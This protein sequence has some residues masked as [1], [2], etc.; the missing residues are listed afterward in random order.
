MSQTDTLTVSLTWT[1]DPDLEL[2]WNASGHTTE[3]VISKSLVA[4][5][6]NRNYKAT[7]ILEDGTVKE[8]YFS[9][10]LKAKHWCLVIEASK[11]WS[12]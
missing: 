4:S 1:P 6:V 2:E 11:N 8:Q 5:P 9:S 3:Y 7:A 12:Y 10:Q